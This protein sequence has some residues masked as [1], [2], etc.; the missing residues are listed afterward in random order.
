M[1]FRMFLMV[2]AI[3]ALALLKSLPAMAQAEV[4]PDQFPSPHTVQGFQGSFTLL[5]QVNY[6]GLTLPAGAYS[7]SMLSVGGW[8]LV[9]LTPE[10]AAASTQAQIKCPSNFDHPTALILEPSGEQSTLTAISFEQP[11]NVL[12]LQGEQNRPVSPEAE[13][14]PVV[15]VSRGR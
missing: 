6:A 5:H 4:L 11:G 15:Y 7:L 14:V 8:N 3:L 12:R 13:Q 10:G 9:T 2:C 1:K